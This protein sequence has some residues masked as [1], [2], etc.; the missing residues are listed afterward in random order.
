MKEVLYYPECQVRDNRLLRHLLVYCEK[1][2][3]IKAEKYLEYNDFTHDMKIVK[4]ETNLIKEIRP[5]VKTLDILFNVLTTTFLRT[6]YLD[7]E[8]NREKFETYYR[9]MILMKN[10]CFDKSPPTLDIFKLNNKILNIFRRLK[11]IDNSNEFNV[12]VGY[13]L[14]YNYLSL[15]SS[16]MADKNNI[17]R[18]TSYDFTDFLYH[19]QTFKS[20]NWAEDYFMAPQNPT[21]YS[22]YGFDKYKESKKRLAS[23]RVNMPMLDY[24]KIP[25]KDLIE[26]RSDYNYKEKLHAFNKTINDY[27]YK[28]DNNEISEIKYYDEYLREHV[29]KIRTELL[30][31]SSHL[32]G[33]SLG[34]SAL[35]S[36]DI[37]VS[38]LST[39]AIFTASCLN[40]VQNVIHTWEHTKNK[41]LSL[42]FVNNIRKFDKKYCG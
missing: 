32:L 9:E 8:K 22:N 18:I 24:E 27:Y 26:L 11:L 14:Y 42:K 1:L 17:D 25:L 39:T 36:E 19:N 4:T 2:H 31:L 30:N 20:Y 3:I 23:I 15:L 16:I 34:V 40:Q 29:V 33:F 21:V 38:S 13:Y 28:I 7:P 10:E 41:R 12:E 37:D 5:D 35:V 6:R